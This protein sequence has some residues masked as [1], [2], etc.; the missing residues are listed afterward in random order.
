MPGNLPLDAIRFKGA[1]HLLSHLAVAALS[2]GCL[3][4]WIK[5]AES[6]CIVKLPLR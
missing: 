1:I 5:K 2:P 6:C 4:F 3:A